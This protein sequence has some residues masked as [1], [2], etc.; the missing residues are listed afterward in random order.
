MM[1]QRIDRTLIVILLSA[2]LIA[3]YGCGE[4]ETSVDMTG[5]PPPTVVTAHVR[6][7][8]VD[9]ATKR[10]LGNARVQL[11]DSQGKIRTILTTQAGVFEFENLPLGEKF[12]VVVELR[13][14][15]KFESIV[16][17]I[18]AE[19]IVK[20][21]VNLVPIP[22]MDELPPGDG[23]SVGAKAPNFNLVD[24]NGKRH[25]LADYAGKQRVVLLFDRGAW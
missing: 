2:M 5:E 14:Y 16:N 4:D 20:I 15:E 24:G 3:A 25:S 13:E 11:V 10:T 17:P 19:E 8:L 21:T 7:L 22:K 6:G 18:G 9:D 23:L 12:T 1:N